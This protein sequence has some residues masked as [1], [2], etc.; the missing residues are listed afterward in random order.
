MYTG[1]MLNTYRALL[2]GDRL[3]WQG[4]MLETEEGTVTVR[5]T[6]EGE[7]FSED[8]GGPQ[9]ERMAA[10]LER[11]AGLDPFAAEDDPAQWEKEQRQERDL[12]RS[13]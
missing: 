13:S 8:A 4:E 12:S 1:A 7:P 6:L 9:G 3:E 5:V 2:R 10:A 11:L